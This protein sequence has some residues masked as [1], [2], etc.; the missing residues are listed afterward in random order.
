MNKRDVANGLK[1][2]GFDE[3]RTRDHIYYTYRSL[4]GAITTVRTKVSHG[5][6]KD[7]G[8]SLLGLMARQCRLS[9]QGFRDLISCSLSREDYEQEICS[10]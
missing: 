3:D 9:I 1:G 7:I 4:S 5:S 6:S 2:K 10:D 8:I